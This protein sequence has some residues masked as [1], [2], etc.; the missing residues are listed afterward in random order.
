MLLVVTGAG[1]SLASGIATFRG[2]DPGAIWKLSDVEL[3][4]REYFERDPVGQWEWYGRRFATVD[5]ARPN[6]AHLALAR[7]EA[8]HVARGG[9]FL[10]VTQNIDTLHEQAG[11][12]QLVKVHGTADRVRCSRF[13]CVHAAPRG[14]L[15]RA[16]VSVEAF[17]SAPSR[18][19]LPRC[20]ACGAILRAHVLFFDEYYSEHEDYEF[21]RANV[22]AESADLV[23]FAGTSFSVGVTDLVLRA[24]ELRSI[25][26]YS[27]DPSAASASPS[28]RVRSIAEPAESVLPRICDALGCVS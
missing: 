26:V 17:R 5:G 19:A 8:W 7:L 6:P 21:E 2:S 11:S 27:I 24:A 12:E 1:V 15:P 18:E 13:G 10:L 4:T 28:R 3:A 20:P 14:S 23:L 22:A 25:P 16:Q 9:R